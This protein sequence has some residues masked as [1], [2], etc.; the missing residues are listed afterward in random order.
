MNRIPFNIKYRELIESGKYKVETGEG[1]SV[2]IICWDKLNDNGST[3]IVALSK[4]KGAGEYFIIC[5]ENGKSGLPNGRND[6]FVISEENEP[7]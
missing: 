3:A 1:E 5:D 6:L 7:E 4:I 2:R